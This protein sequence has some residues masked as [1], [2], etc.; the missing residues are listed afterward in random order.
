VLSRRASKSVAIEGSSPGSRSSLCSIWI[1]MYPYPS[2]HPRSGPNSQNIQKNHNSVDKPKI[3]PV[4]SPSP[5][6]RTKEESSETPTKRQS[7]ERIRHNAGA[8]FRESR[9][10]AAQGSSVE[11]NDKVLTTSSGPSAISALGPVFFLPLYSGKIET[12][13][14]SPMR[15]KGQRNTPSPT[16]QIIQ[17]Q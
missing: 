6:N 7:G 4:S 2:I 17:K 15:E 3:P 5:V 14:P 1:E 8:Q 16:T 11:Q 10:G 13:I 12:R 9:Y